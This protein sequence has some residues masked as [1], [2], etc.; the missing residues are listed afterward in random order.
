MFSVF[1][2]LFF[3][4]GLMVVDGPWLLCLP[5]DMAQTHQVQRYVEEKN[6]YFY[7]YLSAFW[8]LFP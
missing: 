7:I 6:L 2:F 5:R 1:H 3:S 4:S 8:I